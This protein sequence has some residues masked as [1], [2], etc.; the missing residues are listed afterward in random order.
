M[1]SKHKT[2]VAA[3]CEGKLRYDS[4]STAS[5]VLDRIRSRDRV[6]AG[7]RRRLHVYRCGICG[8]W[9][10]GGQDSRQ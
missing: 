9:H 2:R 5:R 6:N 4:Y 1:P 10:L 8:G 3:H 7:K